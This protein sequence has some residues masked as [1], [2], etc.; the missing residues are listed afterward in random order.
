MCLRKS[1][2]K[3]LIEELPIL[4]VIPIEANRLKLQVGG[5]V[6]LSVC[7]RVLRSASALQCVAGANPLNVYN[8][9]T[10]VY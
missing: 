3:V 8:S 10:V 6:Y 2:P 5:R 7:V 4:R 1:P 9:V